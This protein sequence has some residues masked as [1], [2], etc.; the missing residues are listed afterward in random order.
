MDNVLEENFRIL[1][2]LCYMNF[3]KY[4]KNYNINSIEDIFN[5]IKEKIEELEIQI[6]SLEHY[7]NLIQDENDKLIFLD[8]INSKN[9]ELIDMK[10]QLKFI[11]NNN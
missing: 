1:G 6:H 11:K 5:K 9:T 4:L 8:K 7:N 2:I 3:P 10:N